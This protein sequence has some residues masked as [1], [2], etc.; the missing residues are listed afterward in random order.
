VK[1]GVGADAGCTAIDFLGQDYKK[2]VHRGKSNCFECIDQLDIV[3]QVPVSRPAGE[4]DGGD[5]PEPGFTEGE[6]VVYVPLMGGNGRTAV[7][8]IEIHGLV[9]DG[10]TDF[11]K[12]RRS[13]GVIRTMIE[14]KDYK[15]MKYT[16]FWRKPG[17]R[18]GGMI[19]KKIMKK[20][21]KFDHGCYAVVCGKTTE[22]NETLNGVP[23]FGGARFTVA[24]EDG[25]REEAIPPQEFITVRGVMCVVMVLCSYGVMVSWCHGVSLLM[26]WC[27]NI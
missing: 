23:Y 22:A 2:R 10:V 8:L 9:M 11:T 18:S 5:A 1:L 17:D 21:E 20:N 25:L 16:K 6:T 24:W 3:V 7:G 13:D 26:Y 19:P 27:I 14:K 15:F 4:G 12:Y